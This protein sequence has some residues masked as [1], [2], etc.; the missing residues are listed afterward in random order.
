[1]L[2]FR[3]RHF[4]RW[5]GETPKAEISS[6]AHQWLCWYFVSH[7]EQGRIAAC[8]VEQLAVG[9]VLHDRRC[10]GCSMSRVESAAHWR[11]RCSAAQS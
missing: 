3:E 5:L 8:E 7:E 11:I 1:M 6:S 2:T 9:D 10:V 4:R